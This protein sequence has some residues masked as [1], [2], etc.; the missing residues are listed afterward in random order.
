MI[1]TKLS[2]TTSPKKYKMEFFKDGKKFK[3]TKF[4]AFGM[5]DYTLHKDLKRKSL[6]LNRHRKRENWDDFYSAGSLSR[7]ILWNK[8]S[9]NSSYLDYLKKFNLKK[10]S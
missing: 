8:T 2:K 10:K 4:G 6:Y 9:I 7:Y 1:E 5:S 3:T